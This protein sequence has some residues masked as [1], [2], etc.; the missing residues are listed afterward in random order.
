MAERIDCDVL[1]AGGGP[2]GVTLAALIRGDQVLDTYQTERVPNLRATIDMA[3]MMGRTAQRPFWSY[4]TATCSEPA[5]RANCA[6]LFPFV[7]SLSRHA[8]ANLARQARDERKVM[9]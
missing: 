6:S 7:S 3:V 2:T 8:G 9:V 1:I 5:A 4:R